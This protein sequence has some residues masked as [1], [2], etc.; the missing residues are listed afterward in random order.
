MA[1]QLQDRVHFEDYTAQLYQ[2]WAEL[3]SGNVTPERRA[4]LET[5]RDKLLESIERAKD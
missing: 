5:R 4:E 1:A 3:E 2:V